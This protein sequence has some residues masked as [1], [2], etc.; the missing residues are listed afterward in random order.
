[1]RDLSPQ[2]EALRRKIAR[3]ENRAATGSR[4]ADS[5]QSTSENTANLPQVTG[6]NTVFHGENAGGH[7]VAA[8]GNPAAGR[9]VPT[10][11]GRHW[12]MERTWPA[13]YR[14]G[15]SDVG[16]LIELPA[17]ILSELLPAGSGEPPLNCPV[18]RWAFLDTETTGLAGGSGTL[19][20]LVG[21]GSITPAGFGLKQ[22][23]L[24]QPAEEPSLLSALAADLASFDVLVTYNGKAFDVPL[25]E[26]RFLM[27]RQKA[28]FARLQHVDLLYGARR[29]W[30]LKLESCRLQDLE[31]RILGHERVGDVGG[32]FIPNLYFD[33]LRR[34]D[35]GPL[36]PIFFHNA[37]DILSLACLTA[38]VPQAFRDPARLTHG[39]EL[40]GL[41]RWLCHEGRLEQGVVLMRMAL[42][43]PMKEA[44]V[45]ETLWRLADSERKLHRQAAAVAA[46][47]EL[48]SVRNPFQGKALERLAMHYE[49]SEKNLAMAL[50]CTH[51][52]MAIERTPELEKRAARL[53]A[54][55]SKARPGR[56]L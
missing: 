10:P 48:A 8:A 37:I 32:G 39:A 52:A 27:N 1:M 50:E 29:L 33:Y 46:W 20:F 53:A 47:S 24:R 43:R 4:T 21:V 23:F 19:A 36:E 7:A 41:A 31:R 22:Y 6:E 56:L 13:H 2:L 15:V 38:V 17:D 42:E 54:R 44:L 14:H 30:R 45:W 25:L 35:P 18:E 40:A 28:P 12:E 9:E 11:S 16:A 5:P 51:A 49:R 34:S 55:L 26:T 3:L